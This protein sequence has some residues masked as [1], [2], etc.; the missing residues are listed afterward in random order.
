MRRLGREGV[1]GR[2]GEYVVPGEMDWRGK[3]IWGADMA[4]GPGEA[5]IIG[6][7]QGQAVRLCAT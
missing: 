4:G 5:E 7:L 3:A 1:A 2:A 6:V